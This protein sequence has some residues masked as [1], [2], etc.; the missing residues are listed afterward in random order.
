MPI[1]VTQGDHESLQLVI[2]NLIDRGW[3]VTVYTNYEEARTGLRDC[4]TSREYSH[5]RC[6]DQSISL[7]MKRSFEFQATVGGADGANYSSLTV[8][9][10]I[11]RTSEVGRFEVQL[12]CALS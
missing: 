2:I 3:V 5:Q 12:G 11:V 6:E 10:D 9:A 4:F 8:H 1:R 7:I